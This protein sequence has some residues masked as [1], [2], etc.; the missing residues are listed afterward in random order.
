MNHYKF[1]SVKTDIAPIRT[2]NA[3]LSDHR[4]RPP[5]RMSGIFI[6]ERLAN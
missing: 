5:A 2:V 4:L 3:C 1:M 6:P